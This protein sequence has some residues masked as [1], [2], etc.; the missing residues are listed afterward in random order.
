MSIV[1]DWMVLLALGV[2]I[3]A[4]LC[5]LYGF[6]MIVGARRRKPPSMRFADWLLRKWSRQ[7][8]PG[9]LQDYQMTFSTASG[10][11][12]LQ[13]QIDQVYCTV[14]EGHDP[15]EAAHHNGR[16]SVIHDLLVNLDYAEQP[17]KYQVRQEEP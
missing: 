9:L 3:G 14:Y 2:L 1:M 10:Q 17:E 4:L 11:R 13:H 7:V 5:G 15:I 16:R 12:V 6:G 8:D